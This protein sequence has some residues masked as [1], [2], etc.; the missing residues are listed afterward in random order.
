MKST[1]FAGATLFLLA[2]GGAACAQQI[3][4]AKFSAAL[5]SDMKAMSAGALASGKNAV[6]DASVAA[7]AAANVQSNLVLMQAAKCK[8]PTEPVSASHY[9]Q[10][11]LECSMKEGYGSDAERQAACDRAKWERKK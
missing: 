9:I 3:D 1:I 4:C 6:R 7:V 2:A 8:L 5:E 11:A 10:P